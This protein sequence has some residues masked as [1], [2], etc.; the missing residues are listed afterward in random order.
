MKGSCDRVEQLNKLRKE[1]DSE[2]GYNIP[3]ERG[4]QPLRRE[5]NLLFRKPFL[6]DCMEM[7]EIGPIDG[8]G[9]PAPLLPPFGSGN[10]Y[11][12]ST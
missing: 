11:I 10:D 6:K 3:D 7:K 5:W 1:K 9:S 2:S 12:Y 8:N 4:R